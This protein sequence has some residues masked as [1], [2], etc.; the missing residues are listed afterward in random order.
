MAL[1]LL[2]TVPDRE[3]GFRGRVD[4][5]YLTARLCEE[6]GVCTTGEVGNRVEMHAAVY[7][8]TEGLVVTDADGRRF[9]LRVTAEELK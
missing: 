6:A 3:L 7:S 4:S 2:E 5:C 9:R 8:R 1:D